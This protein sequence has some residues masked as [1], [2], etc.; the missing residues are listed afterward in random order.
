MSAEYA[1]VRHPRDA[2]N[3]HPIWGR[4]TAQMLVRPVVNLREL[5]RRPSGNW[6]GT[7]RVYALRATPEDRL[8]VEAVYRT[9]ADCFEAV[10]FGSKRTLTRMLQN[11]RSYVLGVNGATGLGFVTG[12]VF[13]D[14][15]KRSRLRWVYEKEPENETI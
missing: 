2:S 13:E 7:S 9:Q 10:G 15:A 4:L 8:H 14:A 1:P 12:D 5:Y 3:A 11:A 6:K